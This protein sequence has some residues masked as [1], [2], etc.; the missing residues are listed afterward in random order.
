MPWTAG[1]F[2]RKH[3]KKLTPY[4]SAKA[5]KIANAILKSSG[6]EGMAIATANKLARKKPRKKSKP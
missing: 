1:S 3:N 4:Q 6:N 5:A 2:R